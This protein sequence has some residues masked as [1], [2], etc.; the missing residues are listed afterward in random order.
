MTLFKSIYILYFVV[1]LINHSI[2]LIAFV[3]SILVAENFT[4]NDKSVTIGEL[5]D[6][7]CGISTQRVNNIR[8]IFRRSRGEPWRPF[9]YNLTE[10][11]ESN[12]SQ[13]ICDVTAPRATCN[14]TR[15]TLFGVLQVVRVQQHAMTTSRLFINPFKQKHLG[16]YRCEQMTYDEGQ[17]TTRYGNPWWN[18]TEARNTTRPIFGVCMS[19]CENV[20]VSVSLRGPRLY[21]TDTLQTA[22]FFCDG[23]DG[24]HYDWIFNPPRKDVL[25]SEIV[26]RDNVVGGLE[27]HYVIQRNASTSILLVRGITAT[28]VGEYQCCYSYP[29]DNEMKRMKQACDTSMLTSDAYYTY[30]VD[31]YVTADYNPEPGSNFSYAFSSNI[32][33][34]GLKL[35]HNHNESGITWRWKPDDCC[36]K[37]ADPSKCLCL[38]TLTVKLRGH[39]QTLYSNLTDNMYVYEADNTSYLHIRNIRREQSGTFMCVDWTSLNYTETIVRVFDD[40]DVLPLNIFANTDAR[41]PFHVPHGSNVTINATITRPRLGNRAVRWEKVSTYTYIIGNATWHGQDATI[42]LYNVSSSQHDGDYALYAAG[43]DDGMWLATGP[44]LTLRVKKIYVIWR[45]VLVQDTG[46]RQNDTNDNNNDGKDYFSFK[47]IAIFCVVALA[48]AVVVIMIIFAIYK[49]KTTKYSPVTATDT[50]KDM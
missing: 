19:N 33:I 26:Y 38:Q 14:V 48:V 29:I 10:N 45:P 1:N 18:V 21:R 17:V 34:R 37:T 15:R 23:Y 32:T 7:E 16:H 13:P 46:L 47:N 49:I 39:R 3:S 42:K 25:Q 44:S 43:Y 5:V 41:I 27:K 24:G 4:H 36:C 20:S 31:P 28:D 22:V 12:Y 30:Y 2:I 6:I 8:W 40:D 9:S 50:A 11:G 35:Q